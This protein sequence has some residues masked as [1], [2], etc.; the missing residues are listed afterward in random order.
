[1]G[2]ERE[3]G[4]ALAE[5]VVGLARM[6]QHDDRGAALAG[7]VALADDVLEH[8]EPAFERR[9]AEHVVALADAARASDFGPFLDGG[10]RLALELLELAGRSAGR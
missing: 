1:M 6:V 5:H 7:A 8:G 3:I 10:R 2:R 9:L 4:R